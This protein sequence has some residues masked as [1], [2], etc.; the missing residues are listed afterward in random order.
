MRNARITLSV[1]DSTEAIDPRILG[2]GCVGERLVAAA[3]AAAAIHMAM[4]TERRAAP[5]ALR[6]S[7][8][9]EAR[10]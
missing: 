5:E 6:H 8:N 1:V 10:S 3:R 4:A 9:G 7:S 2:V